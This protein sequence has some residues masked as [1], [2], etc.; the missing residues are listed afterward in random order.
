VENNLTKEQKEEIIKKFHTLVLD[1]IQKYDSPET[2]YLMARALSITAIM[3]AEKEYYGF[4]TMQNALNDTAQ[5][6]IALGMGE[7]PTQGDEIF[8]PIMGKNKETIH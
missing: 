5:E 8:E 1:L 3:K 4:L 2:V 6:L 7:P